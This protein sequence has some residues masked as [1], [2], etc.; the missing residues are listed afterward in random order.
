MYDAH[1]A[2][3]NV[4]LFA[5]TTF[6]PRLMLTKEFIHIGHARTACSHPVS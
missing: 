3:R 4:C 5:N 6:I 1:E 2:H